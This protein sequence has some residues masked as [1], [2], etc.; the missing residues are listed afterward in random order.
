MQFNLPEETLGFM[1]SYDPTTEITLS[2]LKGAVGSLI[3]DLPITH[4]LTSYLE[5]C[6]DKGHL[7]EPIRLRQG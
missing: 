7:L 5:I 4:Q 1:G 2:A 6:K 3:I